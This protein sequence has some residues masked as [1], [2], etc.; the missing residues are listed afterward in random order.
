[1]GAVGA[2]TAVQLYGL[3]MNNSIMQ[4]DG[5]LIL[6]ALGIQQFELY[7]LESL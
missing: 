7:G 5:M 1:M 6:E 3:V 2:L 4:S